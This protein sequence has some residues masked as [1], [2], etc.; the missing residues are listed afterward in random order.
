MTPSRKYRHLHIQIPPDVSTGPDAFLE[1]LSGRIRRQPLVARSLYKQAG[2]ILKASQ[3][4]EKLSE[5]ELKEQLEAQRVTIRR[6]GHIPKRDKVKSLALIGAAARHSM[7]LSPYQVQFMAALSLLNGKLAEMATGEGKTLSAALA[8]TLLGWTGKPLHILT[9]NEYLAKRDA[10]ELTPLFTFCNTTVGSIAP[11]M[12]GPER[13]ATYD[14]DIVYT[15]AKDLLADF[16][17]DRL[18][19]PG[20]NA[21]ERLLAKDYLDRSGNANSGSERVLRGLHSA[22]VD[23]ADS[24]LID[25]A[26]TPLIISQKYKNESFNECCIIANTIAGDLDEVEHYTVDFRRRRVHLTNNGIVAIR[27]RS[28]QLPPMWRSFERSLELVEMAINARVFFERDR[29]YILD[30]GKVVIVDQNTG[31]QKAD[32]TWRGGVHQAIEIKEGLEISDATRTMA[33]MT[34]Q[35]YFRLYH[36]LGATTGTVAGSSVEFWHIYNLNRVKIPTHR[37]SGRRHLDD[38]YFPD[39]E[40]KWAAVATAVEGIHSRGQ[41][42]LIGTDSVEASLS[43]AEVLKE[44][45]LSFQLLNAAEHEEESEIIAVAGHKG[46]ITIAT[47]MAGRGTDIKPGEGVTDLGGLFVIACSRM[48]SQR[49]DRQLYGRAGRQGDPGVAQC[50]VSLEDRLLQQAYGPAFLKAARNYLASGAPG[51][52]ALAA[53]LTNKAQKRTE[54]RFQQQRKSVLTSDKWLKES[55]TFSGT[56][57]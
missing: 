37:K 46:A 50:F 3:Q 1:N 2:K 8:A 38:C 15:T 18:L 42:V 57:I 19:A 16:L 56:E 52:R 25:D 53:Y 17:R 21:N 54:Q 5:P 43:V 49:I 34:F 9:S 7:G 6:V 29:D 10:E 24:V 39:L 27:D 47:N 40:A 48:E 26:I 20:V 55:L 31:R 14:K 13:T 36:H 11:E 28:D 45:G 41:P 12:K 32:S 51:S 22:L 35:R 33:S 44:K 4:Y 23:E 30:D